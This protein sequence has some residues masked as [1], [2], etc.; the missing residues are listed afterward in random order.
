MADN[1]NAELI[2][3]ASKLTDDECRIVL[4]LCAVLKRTKEAANDGA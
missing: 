2:E 3:F 4:E 1:I